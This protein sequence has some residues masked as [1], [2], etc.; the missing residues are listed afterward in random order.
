[1]SRGGP[2]VFRPITAGYAGG[3]KVLP[4]LYSLA[5]WS[6]SLPHGLMA[7]AFHGVVPGV[8]DQRDILEL[9]DQL[10]RLAMERA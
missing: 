7:E 10:R 6:T 8:P 9:P 4:Y 3:P 5:G 2:C 1:M